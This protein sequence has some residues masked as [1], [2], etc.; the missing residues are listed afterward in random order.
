MNFLIDPFV[1]GDAGGQTGVC[2]TLDLCGWYMGPCDDLR[3]CYIF[4]ETK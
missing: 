1:Q 2:T 4:W 3:R